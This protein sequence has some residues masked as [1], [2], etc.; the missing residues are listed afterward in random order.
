MQKCASLFENV[1]KA[2]QANVS[3][4]RDLKDPAK[5]V[6]DPEVFSHI[7]QAA[8]QPMVAC[9]TPRIDTFIRQ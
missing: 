8:T 4:A 2:H 3:V 5:I 7:A 9:Y 1:E 6:K